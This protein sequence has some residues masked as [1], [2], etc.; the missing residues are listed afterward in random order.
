MADAVRNELLALNQRL[1]DSIAQADWATYDALCDPSL[2]AFEPEARGQLVEGMAFHRF[3]FDL[4]RSAGPRQTTM[5]S[6]HVRLLGDDVAVIS[7]VRL[8][9]RLASDGAPVT[10]ATEE[11]RIWQRQA[12]TWRHVH[13]HRSQPAG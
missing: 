2:T 10:V 11:S 4:G 7:Y 6:P 1:L 8:V 12:G 13:F 3:Y 5:A 9:Q